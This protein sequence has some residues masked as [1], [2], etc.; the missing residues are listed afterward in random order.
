M[1]FATT[2]LFEVDP[3]WATVAIL[4]ASLPVAANV[5]IVAK[6]YDTYVE[7]ISSAILVSTI[8]SVVTVSTLLTI[9]PLH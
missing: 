8:V 9:L 5:F 7:R 6:H 4:G 3:L 2:Q 1:W